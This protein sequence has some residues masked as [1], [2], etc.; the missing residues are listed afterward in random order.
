MLANKVKVS[1]KGC[2]DVDRC[3]AEKI[4]NILKFASLYLVC[5]EKRNTLYHLLKR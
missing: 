1:E 4:P 5:S 2:C 3:R